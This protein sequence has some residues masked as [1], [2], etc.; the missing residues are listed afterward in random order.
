MEVAGQRGE[1]PGAV[2]LARERKPDVLMVD[3][4]T[5]A[6]GLP[7]AIDEV[8]EVSPRTKVVALEED[9]ITV[10]DILRETGEAPENKG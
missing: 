5:G 9:W 6:T 1:E 8:R 10:R 3:I 4:E 7:A 2:A